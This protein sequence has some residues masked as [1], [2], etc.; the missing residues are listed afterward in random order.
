MDDQ[1][2]HKLV[3]DIS[4]RDF[5]KPFL[6]KATF[7][8]RLR[9]TGGRYLLHTFNIEIN[10]LYFD[11]HGYNEL[12]GIIKHELCHYHLHQAGKGFRHRDKDFQ[13][14]LNKVGGS[15]YCTPIT[16]GKK[17]KCSSPN[18]VYECQDCK[19]HYRRKKRM[20]VSRYVCGICKGKLILV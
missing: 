7:N 1:E 13:N 12:I 5:K 9:T 18:Y 2:L 15:R 20:D 14:L 10:K 8:P 16:S 11:E 17:I 3:E 19:Q 4:I 6:H